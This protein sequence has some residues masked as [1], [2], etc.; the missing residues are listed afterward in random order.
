M[1][2][3]YFVEFSHE[4]HEYEGTVD[5]GKKWAAENGVEVYNIT[6]DGVTVFER[7][8]RFADDGT[9]SLEEREILS[10]G[11]LTP[12]EAVIA[13]INGERLKDKEGKYYEH[14]RWDGKN[15]IKDG[16]YYWDNIDI[17]SEF[18]GLYRRK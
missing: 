12:K 4:H 6:K 18:T 13:M 8:E 1:T 5:D 10:E 17:I 15:F 14:Y 7:F 2:V 16:G 3:W 11:E 9:T